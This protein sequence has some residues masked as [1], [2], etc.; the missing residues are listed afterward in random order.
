MFIFGSN[1]TLNV[2]YGSSGAYGFSCVT[3]AD[4]N[5]D[6]LV[7]LIGYDGT[8]IKGNVFVWTNGIT[9]F[10]SYVKIAAGGESSNLATADLNGDGKPDL[11]VGNTTTFVNVLLNAT[12]FAP[13][14]LNIISAGNQTVLYWNS[15]A[16]DSVLQA[17]TNLNNPDWVNVA[18]G[19][20]ITGV[21]LPNTSP[22]QFFRLKSQ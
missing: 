2:P 9:G 6:G 11:V 16:P 22:V 17:T 19:K 7:D 14:P 1:A 3:A 13:P 15:P 10:G 12:V 5:G 4:M 18:N 21:T 8:Q 20:P